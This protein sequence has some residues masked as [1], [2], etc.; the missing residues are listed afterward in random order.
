MSLANWLG[1][2][3]VLVVLSVAVLDIVFNVWHRWP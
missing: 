1:V 3:A 2:G